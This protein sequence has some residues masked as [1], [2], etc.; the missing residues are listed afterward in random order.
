MDKKIGVGIVGS[1]FIS[2]IHAE[3]LKAVTD[4]EIVAVASPHGR[5]RSWLMEGAGALTDLG[6]PAAAVPY[7]DW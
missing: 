1:Q 3:A 4:A 2:T 7:G 6:L 5:S